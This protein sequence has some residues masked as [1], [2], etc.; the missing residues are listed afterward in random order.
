MT[1]I[2]PPG[3]KMQAGVVALIFSIFTSFALNN[4]S[5]KDRKEVAL[6]ALDR[7]SFPV[8]LDPVQGSEGREGDRLSSE[9]FTGEI[10]N[11]VEGD[12]IK[13]S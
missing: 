3:C 13:I 4:F 12:R 8:D 5:R 11:V 9:E 7:E 1:E 2:C 6:T 10:A